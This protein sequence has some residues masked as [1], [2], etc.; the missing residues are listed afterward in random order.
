M[1]SS[2]GGLCAHECLGVGT[3]KV[4]WGDGFIF[5][6]LKICA[7]GSFVNVESSAAV[8]AIGFHTRRERET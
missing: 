1:L 8:P 6:L 4:E 7:C 5:L 2:S 3:P